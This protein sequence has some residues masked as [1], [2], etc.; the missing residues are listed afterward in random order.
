MTILIYPSCISIDT[1]NLHVCFIYMYRY[2][3]YLYIYMGNIDK[4]VNDQNL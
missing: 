2:I 4:F 3:K 1:G